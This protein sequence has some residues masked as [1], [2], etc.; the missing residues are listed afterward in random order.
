[1]AGGHGVRRG[2]EAAREPRAQDS[3]GG[4]RHAEDDGEDAVGPF[5]V[6]IGEDRAGAVAVRARDGERVREQR[7]QVERGGDP[8]GEDGE[9]AEEHGHAEAEDGAGPALGHGGRLVRGPDP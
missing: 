5:A 2:G 8:D 6:G 1:M 9:P 7:R 4:V 3:V